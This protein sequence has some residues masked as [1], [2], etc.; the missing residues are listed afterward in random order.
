MG[1]YLERKSFFKVNEF[2]KNSLWRD[3]T[4]NSFLHSTGDLEPQR[5]AE[6]L[7]EQALTLQHN[8]ANSNNLALS[9][10]RRHLPGRHMVDFSEEQTVAWIYAR[11]KLLKLMIWA[12]CCYFKHKDQHLLNGMVVAFWGEM[13]L[14]HCHNLKPALLRTSLTKAEEMIPGEKQ[15]K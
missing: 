11:H 13:F 10:V 3:W 12:K 15:L 6:S 9:V 4:I 1:G 8:D 7:A 14:V 2:G 5:A